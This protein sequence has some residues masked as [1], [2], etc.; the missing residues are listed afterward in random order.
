MH[1]HLQFLDQLLVLHMRK[2]PRFSRAS[3]LFV[4]WFAVLASCE[5]RFSSVFFL[6]LGLSSS[7]SGLACSCVITVIIHVLILGIVLAVR[8]FISLFA[9][10]LWSAFIFSDSFGMPVTLFSR[11]ICRQDWQEG[12]VDDGAGLFD[13]PMCQATPKRNETSQESSR[14]VGRVGLRPSCCIPLFILDS[15]T[16]LVRFNF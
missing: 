16:T 5:S 7:Q 13:F 9:T 10:P 8:P 1:G 3:V 15:L 4:S 6:S 14:F 11:R 2:L 12:L